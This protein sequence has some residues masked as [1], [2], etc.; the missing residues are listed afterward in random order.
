MR[1]DKPAVGGRVVRVLS[2]PSGDGPLEQ[3]FIVWIDDNWKA[4]E[5][6]VGKSGNRVRKDT[7]YWQDSTE[8]GREP[9]PAG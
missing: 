1:E 8:E 7:D 3:F 4:K 5:A 9:W 2:K 6:G